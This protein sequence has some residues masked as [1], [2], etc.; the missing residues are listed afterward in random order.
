M[1][2]VK[3]GVHIFLVVLIFGTLWRLVSYHLMASQNEHFNHI[4]KAMITQY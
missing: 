2:D 3:V 4:G 1:E